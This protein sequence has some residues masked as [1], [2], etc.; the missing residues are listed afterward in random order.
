MLLA[1]TFSMYY[2][3]T[4]HYTPGENVWEELVLWEK[5]ETM[6][7]QNMHQNAKFTEKSQL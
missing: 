4:Q 1:Q 2:Q 5:N 3:D 7:A 6:L